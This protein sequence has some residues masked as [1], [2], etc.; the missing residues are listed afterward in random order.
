MEIK[1]IT[2]GLPMFITGYISGS[3]HWQKTPFVYDHDQLAG[4][5]AEILKGGF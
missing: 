3:E 5:Y 2:S 4:P 1:F